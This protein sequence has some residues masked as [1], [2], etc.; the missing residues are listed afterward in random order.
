MGFEAPL[1]NLQSLEFWGAAKAF[2]NHSTVV[3]P[4]ALH[5]LVGMILHLAIS[6]L[7]RTPLSS[8]RPWAVLLALALLNEVLDVA[9]D[10]WPSTGAQSG[11]G[12]KDIVLTMI[13]PTMLLI[14]TRRAPRLFVPRN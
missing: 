3:S 7:I 11:E 10:P 12:A 6:L 8:I 2:V 5:V 9:V 1:E 13:L 4:D 14:A